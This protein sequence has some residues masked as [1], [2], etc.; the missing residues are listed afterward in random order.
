MA[1]LPGFHRRV[2]IDVSMTRNLTRTEDLD[3]HRLRLYL[4]GHCIRP[5]TYFTHYL[6]VCL[7]FLF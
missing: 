3:M 5:C 4:S 7:L 6:L 1:L 2:S